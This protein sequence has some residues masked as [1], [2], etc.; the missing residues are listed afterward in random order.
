MKQPCFLSREL[1]LIHFTVIVHVRN[2][3]NLFGK[4]LMSMESEERNKVIKERICAVLKLKTT[5]PIIVLSITRFTI[6]YSV[7]QPLSFVRFAICQK[8][9]RIFSSS[10]L[11]QHVFLSN[12][13]LSSISKSNKA[14]SLYCSCLFCFVLQSCSVKSHDRGEE[15]QVV[16][17][18]SHFNSPS[19]LLNELTI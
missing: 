13:K 18:T 4:S 2:A 15:L 3:R 5:T 1:F 10:N 8:Q 12:V 14:L 19:V 7:M 6:H 17:Q 16:F 11:I 9:K